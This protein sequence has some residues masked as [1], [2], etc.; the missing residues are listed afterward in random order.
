[1]D[2]KTCPNCGAI[3]R[4]QGLV[5]VC[6]FCGSQFLENEFTLICSEKVSEHD[7]KERYDYIKKNEHYIQS[8]NLVSL[9][10][11]GDEYH[12]STLL[13]YFANDGNFSLR[14]DFSFNITYSN[15]NDKDLLLLIV[16]SSNYVPDVHLSFLINY[17]YIINP[18]FIACEGDSVIFQLQIEELIIV[19]ES[20]HISIYSNF[21]DPL[22]EHFDEFKYYCCRFFHYAFNK[23][24]YNY[25]IYKLLIS[26]QYGK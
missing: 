6:E 13:P 15:S 9:S 5:F 7:I 19:C 21:F 16:N 24:K 18:T 4:R 14:T 25:S 3:L 12:I 11:S 2:N 8:N 10:K 26:D 17:K 22:I 20:Y 23:L 1:M